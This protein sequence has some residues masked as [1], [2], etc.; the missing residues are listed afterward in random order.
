MMNKTLWWKLAAFVA[1]L[2]LAACA[3]GKLGGRGQNPVN[4]LPGDNNEAP[5]P[6][7]LG[8]PADVAR[9][10]V[11][12]DATPAPVFDDRNTLTILGN[13]QV[14]LN[15]INNTTLEVRYSDFEGNPVRGGEVSFEVEDVASG[16]EIEPGVAPTNREGVARVTLTSGTAR[17]NTRVKVSAFHAE[18]VYYNI[19]VEPK[20][21]AAYI[22]HTEYDGNTTPNLVSVRLYDAATRCDQLDPMALPTELARFDVLPALDGIPDARFV[23]LPNGRGYTAVSVGWVTEEARA[24]WGCNDD[25]PVVT[26]GF[27]VEVTVLMEEMRPMLE[28]TF[29]IETRV[30]LTDALP[31]PWRTNLNLIGQIF[32]DPASL[33]VD[34]LLGVEAD[35]NDDGLIGEFLNIIPGIRQLLGQVIREL[36]IDVL[37]PEVQRVFEVGGAVYRVATEFTLGG[38]LQFTAE[39][40]AQGFLAVNNAHRYGEIMLNWDIDCGLNDPPE[41][42]EIVLSMNRLDEVGALNGQFA[43]QIVGLEGGDHLLVDRHSFSFNY[44]ALLLALFEQIILPEIFGPQVDSIDDAVGTLFDCREIADNVFDPIDNIIFNELL[45]RGCNDALGQ[46]VGFL[47]DLILSN[48]TE[49]PALSIGTFPAQTEEDLAEFGCLLSEPS[50]YAPGQLQRVYERLGAEDARCL[51][52]ARLEASD[53]TRQIDADFVGH[54]R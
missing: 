52:D 27:D 22:V 37:P 30:D 18:A 44:G 49:V 5:S 24:A 40:D 34:L 33:A 17:T 31:E 9:P 35:P 29:P 13:S 32:T 8:S 20:D 7:D 45:F 16:I 46:F 53:E 48:D 12:D 28:G 14:G 3:D 43:G 11:V 26:D 42:G 51:W 2:S 4:D 19:R 25:A 36:L 38:Q 39:P 21:N 23:D 54:R 47:L 6:V 41:C 15:Y 50:P 1:A 10:P